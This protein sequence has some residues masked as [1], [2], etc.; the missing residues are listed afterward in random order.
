MRGHEVNNVEAVVGRIW[1]EILVLDAVGSDDN[2]FALG[3][4]SLKAAQVIARVRDALGVEL[5]MKTLFER[6]TVAQLAAAIT[7]GEARPDRGHGGAVNG[8]PRPRPRSGPVPL[9][10]AQ[11]RVW[12]VQQ[13]DPGCRA[14]NFQA[15][16]DFRGTLDTQA[17]ERVLNRI[18]ERHEILRTTFPS[19]DGKPVQVVHPFEPTPL[20]VVDL[21]HWASAERDHAVARITNDEFR[22]RFDAAQLPLIRW[23][24]L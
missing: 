16:I 3:G 15:T 9:T 19:V 8:R 23:T 12:F 24:L 13:L 14:Y 7:A 22:R 6:P 5:E 21:T 17:L 2:F 4:Q 20:V 11:E 10:F 18:V 1:E